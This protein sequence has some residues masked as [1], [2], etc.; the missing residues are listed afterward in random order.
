MHTALYGPDLLAAAHRSLGYV[1]SRIAS[2]ADDSIGAAW[3]STSAAALTDIPEFPSPSP[4]RPSPRR[5]HSAPEILKVSPRTLN[6]SAHSEKRA[7]QTAVRLQNALTEEHPTANEG[8]VEW[9][10]TPSSSP[11]KS[12]TLGSPIASP[13]SKKRQRMDED[14]AGSA[15]LSCRLRTRISTPV[16]RPHKPFS[17]RAPSV[18]VPPSSLP[19]LSSS[20]T[21]PLG[22]KRRLHAAVT[23]TSALALVSKGRLKPLSLR[24]RLRLATISISKSRSSSW[25]RSTR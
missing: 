15:N 4:E 19:H 24:S 3:R 8:G 1:T 2:P 21:L 22:S 13:L 7:L 16:I 11:I 14:D 20:P 17:P 9:L 12:A 25:K 23:E 5:M 18:I 10:T 6:F